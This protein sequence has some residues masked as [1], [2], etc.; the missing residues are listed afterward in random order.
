MESLEDRNLMAG[1]TGL[2]GQYF[3]ATNLTG[4]KVTRTDPSINFNWTSASPAAGVASTNFS[5]RWSGYVQPLYSQAYT[6][7]TNSDDGVRLWVNNVLLVN[8]WTGHGPTVDTGSIN[9]V[10]GQK[11]SIKMEYFQA[12]GGSVAQLFWSSASQAKQ[13]IPTSQLFTSVPAPVPNTGPT[14]KLT[15]G[16]VTTGGG[17]A[18]TFTV[19][20]T[21][22]D[23]INFASLGSGDV[24]VTGPNGYN[25]VGGL[26][27]VNTTGNGTPRTAT[28]RIVANGGTWDATDN[29]T[30]TVI[31]V[32]NQVSDTKGA[33]AT[34]VTLGTFQVT[35]QASDW[36][37]TNL[38]DVAVRNL[39]RTLHVDRSLSRNDMIAVFRSVQSNG[40]S[41][42]EFADLQTLVRSHSYLGMPDHVRDLSNKVAYG[43]PANARYLGQALGNLRVGS[44]GAQLEM[45]VGKWFLGKDHPAAL[46]YTTYVTAAGTLFGAGPAYTDVKQGQVADCYFLA[47]LA[48]TA[49]RNPNAIRNM[50]IDNGDGTYT[51]RFMNGSTP[52]Y[53]TVDR[54][55][56][57][58]GSSYVYANFQWQLGNASNK[59][60][61]PLL[62][63]AYAQL[64]ESGWSRSN[65]TANAY[66]T[67][68]LGWE[69]DALRHTTGTQ[70]TFLGMSGDISTFNAIVGAFGQ[71]KMV[72]L[73]T[74]P[75]T[76]PAYVANH[77]YVMVGY[78]STNGAINLYNPWGSVQ[79]VSWNDVKANFQ[80]WTRSV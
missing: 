48:A 35:V 60:W 65:S 66:S 59:L 44:T 41:A 38:R 26:L 15:A 31:L 58:T 21:D 54:M 16:N 29:G 28:Y 34:G 47:A 32:G 43:D 75:T 63:K 42:N 22:A 55:L 50:F 30:Y 10:A 77:V 67:I 5:V 1:G 69:G 18:H 27:S 9:L 13:L 68:S 79:Q 57:T 19:T 52:T 70:S 25:I 7:Y 14:A 36:Y 56:P 6:F 24:R 37:T 72:M 80:G 39:V 4:L 61:V 51:V 76:N 3:S 2:T 17:N 64:A 46:G 62:E 53:V 23:G 78:N 33:F 45:L 12:A 40:V 73:E 11:Y 74:K 8:N 49:F 20:Y 71:G